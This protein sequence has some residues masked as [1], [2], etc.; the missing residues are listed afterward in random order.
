V[1]ANLHEHMEFSDPAPQ[2]SDRAFGLL[3]AAVFVLGGIWLVRTAESAWVIDA[4]WSLICFAAVFFF[5]AFVR[6]NLL[7][8]MNKA[9]MLVGNC[10]NRVVSPLVMGVVWLVV[11]TPTG[12]IRRIAGK[13][14]MARTFDAETDSYWIRRDPP[15]PAPSTLKDQF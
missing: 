8:S 5:T 7:H 10:L 15:G 14:S 9:W 11:V 1:K 3:F 13:D 6:P 2:S 12:L 4:G